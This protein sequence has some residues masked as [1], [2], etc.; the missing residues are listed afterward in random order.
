M[1]GIHVGRDLHSLPFQ[2]EVQ[3]PEGVSLERHVFLTGAPR[4]TTA[5]RTTTAAAVAAEE[6][7]GA[8]G[9]ER[10]PG[11]RYHV[12][13]RPDRKALEGI[14]GAPYS[15]RPFGAGTLSLEGKRSTFY[16]CGPPA[17]EATAVECLMG[18]GAPAAAIHKESFSAAGPVL[19]ETRRARVRFTLSQK[20]AVWERD[21][22][23]SLLELAEKVGLAPE[24]GCRVGACG[25]CAAKLTC[26]TVAGGVQADS[27]VL[28]CSATPAS[29]YVELAL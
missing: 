22:P 25:S 5:T 24:Y 2:G 6:E 20:E 7:T 15:L 23:V 12:G 18:L 1:L 19:A 16:V 21:A 28:T 3:M 27:S 29:E 13:K 9:P 26:G 10:Q 14:L 4:S 8:V 11:I 17:F